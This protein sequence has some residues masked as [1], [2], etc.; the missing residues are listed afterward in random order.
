MNT[1]IWG[2]VLNFALIWLFE[3]FQILPVENIWLFLPKATYQESLQTYQHT[4]T[5]KK[6]LNLRPVTAELVIILSQNRKKI[7]SE[8]N[9]KCFQ[10]YYYYYKK[11]ILEK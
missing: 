6:G 4:T 8:I 11:K 2:H 3:R 5:K 9:V 7:K 1:I 10:Y